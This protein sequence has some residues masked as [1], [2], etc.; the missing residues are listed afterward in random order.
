MVI[1]VGTLGEVCLEWQTES[2]GRMPNMAFW[3]A[4]GF[5]G[6]MVILV[7]TLGIEPRTIT[8]KGCCSTDWATFPSRLSW[9]D[10]IKKKSFVYPIFLLVIWPIDESVLL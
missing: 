8:L 7:G 9:R 5:D 1:L 10:Y 2:T 6:V 4:I 3:V